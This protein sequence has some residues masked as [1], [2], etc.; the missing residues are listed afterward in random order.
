MLHCVP[1]VDR[2]MF[3][4]NHITLI[5]IYYGEPT[6]FPLKNNNNILNT[7]TSFHL[8]KNSRAR[9]LLFVHG[10]GEKKVPYNGRF[11]LSML[12]IMMKASTT[13][14]SES[15]FF[16]RSRPLYNIVSLIHYSE[17]ER[18]KKKRE[19]SVTLKALSTF[20]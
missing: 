12:M 15:R 2:I 11:V 19:K 14:P 10:W 3:I 8:A 18:C 5:Y 6:I 20:Q 1:L 7:I 17:P 9:V 16:F 4:K 13:I